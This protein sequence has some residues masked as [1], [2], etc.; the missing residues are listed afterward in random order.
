MSKSKKVV[1]FGSGPVAAASLA[2]LAS[3]FTIEAIIT[4]P[5]PPHHRGEVPVLEV[6]KKLLAKEGAI[7]IQI[8]HHELGYIN[9]LM[10]EVFDKNL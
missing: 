1:F 2:L 6:A 10:D 5:K 8:D 9:V 4:K 7:F 3:D